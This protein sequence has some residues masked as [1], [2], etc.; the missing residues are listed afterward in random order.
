MPSS[1][2]ILQIA[3][4]HPRFH[5]GGTELTAL[6]LHREAL[7]QGLDSWYLGALDGTQIT[8]N[9]GTMM[10]ALTPDQR[11]SAL[12]TNS[13]KRFELEQPEHH[14]FLREFGDYLKLIRPDVVHIH[15]VLNFGLEALHVL[16]TALPEARIV[17]SIHDFYLICA[18]NGQL[19]KHDKKERCPGPSM[20][21]CLKCFPNRNANDFAMRAL[22]IRNA[23]SLCDNLVSPSRFLKDKL[24][25]HLGV[26]MEISVVENGYLGSEPAVID[27]PVRRTGGPI[28]G[29]FGNISAV[30]GLAGLL[31]AADLL[32]E[33]GQVD[34]SIHIHGAQLFE[35]K[36]LADRMEAAKETL[37]RKITF[38][39]GYQGDE[40]ASLLAHVDCMVFPSV[41]WENAPLVVY[42][43]LHARR[44]VI[45]YPHGGA[46]EILARYGVGIIAERSDPAALADAMAKVIDDRSLTEISLSRPMP[47]RRDLFAA[48][49]KFYFG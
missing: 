27:P 28:F 1:K 34:F 43:A 47:L 19:Y 31:D 35:D 12:F 20:D 29:Y 46:P 5:P 44:Q 13:F 3:H 2:R 26:P 25:R 30:K 11:G 33:S 6:A 9:E 40:L 37:G 32:I 39:G 10:I 38:F 7:E 8:P 41:W 17:L 18:N 23:L 42:E 15:H 14:G 22:D 36:V 45:A 16:R 4:N 24:D 21:Q 48:Y 49:G